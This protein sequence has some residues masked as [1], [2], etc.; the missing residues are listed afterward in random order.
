MA[1]RKTNNAPAAAEIEAGERNGCRLEARVSCGTKRQRSEGEGAVMTL[2][3]VELI[4][5]KRLF[6]RGVAQRAGTLEFAGG[7]L[8]L[9]PAVEAF[10]DLYALRNW[11]VVRLV[12]STDRFEQ[13]LTELGRRDDSRPFEHVFRRRPP[14]LWDPASEIFVMPGV[15]MTANQLGEPLM[16]AS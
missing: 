2:G 1:T 9:R 3:R 13:R 16:I 7:S 11:N 10:E 8:R 4:E 15:E 12:Y 5:A 14:L 6:V